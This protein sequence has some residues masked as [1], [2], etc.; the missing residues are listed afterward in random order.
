ML[1]IRNIS[2]LLSM[3]CSFWEKCKN[4]P[5]TGLG[6]ST[7]LS[8]RVPNVERGRI[9]YSRRCRRHS[10][11]SSEPKDNRVMITTHIGQPWKCF[12]IGV[13][14][15]FSL[16]SRKPCPNFIEIGDKWYGMSRIHCLRE[17][18][19]GFWSGGGLQTFFYIKVGNLGENVIHD[20]LIK[21]HLFGDFLRWNLSIKGEGEMIT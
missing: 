11:I 18:C 20:L 3:C 17:E 2:Y 16:Q 4:S 21:W 6:C 10:H 9:V 5:K 12:S 13:L 14:S 7:P 8:I 19:K 1:P 15:L